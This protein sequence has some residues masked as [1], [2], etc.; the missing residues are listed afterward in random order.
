MFHR[1]KFNKYYFRKMFGIKRHP[2]TVQIELAGKCSATCEFCDWTKRPAHQKVFMDTELA[3]KAVQEAIELHADQIS[4]HITGESLDHPD[5]L[6]ILPWSYPILISTNCLS[7]EGEIA[8]RLARMPN[9]LIILAVLWS[10]PKE[11]REQ[12]IH[13]AVEYLNRSPINRNISLQM[14]CSEHAV[15]HVLS[16]PG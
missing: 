16:I 6:S 1:V 14:I 3:N 9:L 5:I 11:K 15:P 8:G 4:F 12:S 2:M 10:E 7:L 13:N